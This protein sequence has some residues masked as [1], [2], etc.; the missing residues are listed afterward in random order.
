MQPE[1]KFVGRKQPGG[2]ACEARRSKE[3]GTTSWDYPGGDRGLGT[4]GV[5]AGPF[6][7]APL[8]EPPVASR[9]VGVLFVAAGGRATA[10][11]A[12]VDELLPAGDHGLR[13]RRPIDPPVAESATCLCDLVVRD[14]VGIGSDLTEP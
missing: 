9:G 10:S 8:V 11:Q 3:K 1:K 14:E 4:G 2:S 13:C 6:V 5:G 12:E 7:G